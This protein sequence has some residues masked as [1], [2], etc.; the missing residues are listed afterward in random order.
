[1]SR[2]QRTRP[3]PPVRALHL[4]LGSFFRAHQAWFTHAATDGAEWGIAA[5]SGRSASLADALSGQDCLYLLDVRD[6]GGD[7]YEVMESVVA[8]YPG[9]DARAWTDYWADPQVRYVT[10]TVTEAGYH[11]DRSRSLDERDVEVAADIDAL[12]RGAAPDLVGLRT[13]PGRVVSGLRARRAVDAGPI[14]LVPCD[15]LPNNGAALATA[16]SAVARR[17]DPSLAEWIEASATFVSTVVD[18]ITPATTDAD[19]A[20]VAS[21]TGLADLAPV[22]TEPFADWV[23]ATDPGP[24][25]PMWGTAGAIWTSDTAVYEARK[26]TLLNGSHSLLAYAGPLRGHAT[27]ADAIADD[28]CRSWVEEWWD[29]ACAHLPMAPDALAGYRSALLERFSNSAIEHRLA[30]IAQDGS[31]KL[32]VRVLPTLRAERAAGRVPTGAARVIAAW[33]LSLR[34]SAGPASDPRAAELVELAG[35]PLRL[36]VRRVL[37]DLDPPLAEDIELVAAVVALA[38]EIAG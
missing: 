33:V 17:V 1:M 24:S 30:Q 4:G 31:L 11:L 5:F 22:V 8:A 15:N 9:S 13:A 10:L 18:R 21:D 36:G 32:P 16:V 27:V 35:G 7:R 38:E 37:G 6:P 12:R 3:R 19:R 28:A 23:L 2:L 34:T 25:L 20:R 14:A 26:L 29:E